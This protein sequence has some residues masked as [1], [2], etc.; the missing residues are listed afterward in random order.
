MKRLMILSIPPTQRE[1]EISEGWEG[2]KGP[3][4]SG[5]RGVVSEIKNL[6]SQAQFKIVS[7]LL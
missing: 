4:N 6:D 7:Y 3:G 5:G 1:M 2:I